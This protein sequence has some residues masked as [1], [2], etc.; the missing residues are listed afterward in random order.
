MEILNVI[1][2]IL[3]IG[4]AIA[5]LGGTLFALAALLP[6]MKVLDEGFKQNLMSVAQKRFYRISHPAIVLL[7][8]TGVYQWVSNSGV[9]EEAGPA[10]HGVLG[11]KILLALAIFVIIF[12]QTFGVIRNPGRWMKINLAMGTVV[13][14]LAAVLRHLHMAALAAG[15]G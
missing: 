4:S 8:L 13:V 1:V 10:L 11:M 12:A 3:H 2:R 5:L 15:G 6:A 7:L 14:I 9:Y